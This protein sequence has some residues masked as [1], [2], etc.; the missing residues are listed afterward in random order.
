MFGQLPEWF[1]LWPDP[2]P[3]EGVVLELLGVVVVVL[4]DEDEEPP[5]AALAR[6]A[7]PPAITPRTTIVARAL[8]ALRP[9]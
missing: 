5:L 6:A 8:R 1:W 9:V 7:P 3:F 4:A 2:L